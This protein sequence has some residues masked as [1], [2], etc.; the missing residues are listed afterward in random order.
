MIHLAA[1]GEEEK[2]AAGRL[3]ANTAA[4]ERLNSTT[5]STNDVPKTRSKRF[6]SSLP[7][8]RAARGRASY[9][10]LRLKGNIIYFYHVHLTTPP[11][12]L[13]EARFTVPSETGSFGPIGPN[14]TLF[15]RPSGDDQSIKAAPLFLST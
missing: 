11:L 1:S 4:S 2:L 3:H 5:R 9:K 7:E 12:P 15:Y 8:R 13:R 14:R 6:I 10:S